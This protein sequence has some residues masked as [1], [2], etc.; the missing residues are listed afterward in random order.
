MTGTTVAAP[1]ATRQAVAR[2]RAKAEGLRPGLHYSTSLSVVMTVVLLY[3]MVPLVWLIINSTKSQSDLYAT[4]GLW[5]GHHFVLF[6]NLH[7]LFTIENG[8]YGRWLLNTVFYA[9][10]TAVGSGFIGALAGYAMANYEFPGKKAF[11]A[12]VL[13]AVMIPGS[14]LAV[15]IFLLSSKVGLANTAASVILP[16]LASPFALYLMW[17]YTVRAVPT[18]LIEAA[19]ADGASE[20]RIFRSIAL[21]LVAP[22]LTSVILFGL[23]SA[24]NNYFF[25][26]ILLSSPTKLPIAVG[27]A[28]LNG[29]ATQ[30]NQTVLADGIYPLVLVGSVVA[31]VPLIVAFLVLQRYWQSGLATGGLKL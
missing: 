13:G 24:W 7:R 26:L 22:G 19:R 9:V 11:F 2:K 1:V 20:L 3:F 17:V 21:R 6:H 18:E 4:N 25:P 30:T 28:Q 31:I 16:G 14:V 12:V 23:T 29:Q 15:P 8:I 10:V 27:L 5:F